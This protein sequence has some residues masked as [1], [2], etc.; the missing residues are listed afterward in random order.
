MSQVPPEKIFKH[1]RSKVKQKFGL[2]CLNCLFIK[3]KIDEI[4]N[5]I[6]KY[7]IALP[8][9]NTLTRLE[10]FRHI[11]MH[12][13]NLF[14]NTDLQKKWDS[15]LPYIAEIVLNDSIFK[16]YPITKKLANRYIK[17]VANKIFKGADKGI[18]VFDWTTT[19]FVQKV[20]KIAKEKKYI[21]VSLPHGDRVY[22]SQLDK[23]NDLDYNCLDVYRPADVFNYL[24]VP[25]KICSKRYINFLDE[26]KIKSLVDQMFQNVPSGLGSKSKV[27]FNR[28][29]LL[30]IMKNG[31]SAPVA[32]GYGWEEDPSFL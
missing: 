29:E 28:S 10:Y 16:K 11:V 7:R 5:F 6:E 17:R 1:L 14:Y 9:E 20:V 12:F 25:N 31:A 2:V 26:N 22:T 23:I 8:E 30:E 4:I 15:P 27:R 32:K 13:T 24:V 21:T 18:V 3:C 19:Y